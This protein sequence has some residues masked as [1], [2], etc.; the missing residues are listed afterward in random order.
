MIPSR[1]GHIPLRGTRDN[2]SWI[3]PYKRGGHSQ[4]TKHILFHKLRESL[5]ADPLHNFGQQDK[6]RVVVVVL[7][8]RGSLQLLLTLQH[9]D[10]L[11]APK[12]IFA[13]PASHG[14][15]VIHLPESVGM[16]EHVFEFNHLAQVGQFGNML[17]HIVLQRQ[18]SLLFQQQDGRGSKLFGYRSDVA[19]CINFIGD[20]MA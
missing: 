15:E 14:H 6:G 17:A 1:I 9:F 7:R 2:Y 19:W 8:S 16:V 4:G 18:L 13:L 12:L 10:D 20:P 11:P 5:S 3:W